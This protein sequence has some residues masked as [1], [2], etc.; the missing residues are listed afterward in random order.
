M[1]YR[2]IMTDMKILQHHSCTN[3]DGRCKKRLNRDTNEYICRVPKQRGDQQATFYPVPI[4]KVYDD[5]SIK[6]LREITGDEFLRYNHL[7]QLEM[8]PKRWG[9]PIQNNVIRNVKY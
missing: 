9:K 6:V 8:N 1:Q 2:E 4:H 3:A 5:K 7:N